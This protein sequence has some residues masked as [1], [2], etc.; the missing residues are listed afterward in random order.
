M[1]ESTPKI[2]KIVL[3]RYF[4]HNK[5][6]IDYNKLGTI[7]HEEEVMLFVNT[8]IQYCWWVK[9]QLFTDIPSL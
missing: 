5:V 2:K 3:C 8:E 6:Y 9:K 7:N 4:K 1:A